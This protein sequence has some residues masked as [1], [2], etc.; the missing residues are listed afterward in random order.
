M[1]IKL[2]QNTE[3]HKKCCITMFTV[4]LKMKN[5]KKQKGKSQTQKQLKNQVK[6]IKVIQSKRQMEEKNYK[7]SITKTSVAKSV[8][9]QNL[10]RKIKSV[11]IVF[12]NL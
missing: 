9:V 8:Y 4:S 3:G 1:Q 2:N 5:N 7:H 12:L 11:T 6:K 10:K